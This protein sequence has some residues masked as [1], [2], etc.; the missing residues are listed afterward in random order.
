MHNIPEEQ[1]PHAGIYFS[2]SVP[3]HGQMSVV[4]TKGRSQETVTVNA[5]DTYEQRV[6][7]KFYIYIL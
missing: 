4:M 3:R 7:L 6:S 1:M 2:R 5:Q